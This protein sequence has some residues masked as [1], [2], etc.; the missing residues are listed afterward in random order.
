MLVATTL[1][2]SLIWFLVVYS[3]FLFLSL[4]STYI[5]KKRNV[6]KT[7]YPV[8]LSCCFSFVIELDHWLILTIYF[9][10]KKKKIKLLKKA[11]WHSSYS[12]A[13][14]YTHS[15]KLQSYWS[16]YDIGRLDFKVYS[17]SSMWL[18]KESEVIGFF[19]SSYNWLLKVNEKEKKDRQIYLVSFIGWH[20]ANQ[21][22][23]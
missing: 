23:S 2:L 14:I 11:F 1:L 6:R 18:R 3:C 8:S 10:I 9:S 17:F 12:N 4:F 13:T 20:K 15:Y 16:M 5:I 19:S 7:K 22:F 21:F